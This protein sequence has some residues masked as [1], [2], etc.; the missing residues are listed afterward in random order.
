M[1]LDGPTIQWLGNGVSG[2]LNTHDFGTFI[3]PMKYG[4]VLMRE[5]AVGGSTQRVLKEQEKGK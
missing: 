3:A 1:I 2:I 5:S 4:D